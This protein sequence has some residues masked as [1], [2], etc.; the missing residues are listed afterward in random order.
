MKTCL[1]TVAAAFAISVLFI[2][3]SKLTG[4]NFD[5][6]AGWF[7]CMAWRAIE[8]YYEGPKT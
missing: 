2:A 7:S 3:L 1:V 6:L 8:Q 4:W 5:Y